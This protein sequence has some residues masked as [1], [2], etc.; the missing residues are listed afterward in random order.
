L[1]GVQDSEDDQSILLA[2]SALL[3]GVLPGK[4]IVIIAHALVDHGLDALASSYYLLCVHSSP[5]LV[6][7]A[8]VRLAAP[9]KFLK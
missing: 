8:V 5:L 6:L 4:G 7:V 1:S 3:D 2:K 9:G